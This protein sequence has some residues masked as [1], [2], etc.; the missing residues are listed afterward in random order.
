METDTAY[1]SQDLR[2]ADLAARE[3]RAVVLAINKWDIAED[4]G[5][6]AKELREM[7][8]RLLPQLRGVPVV[9]VSG[10]T[11]RGLNRLA[12]AIGEAHRSGTP[13]SRRPG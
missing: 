6:R 12:E 3:G 8:G 11:G 2:I 9:T 1:E 13:G 5:A 4:R 7:A 10:L